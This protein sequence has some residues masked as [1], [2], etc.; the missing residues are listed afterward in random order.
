MPGHAQAPDPA[1]F[2]LDDLAFQACAHE[3]VAFSRYPSEHVL[4]EPAH[5]LEVGIFREGDAEE[6]LD[7]FQRKAAV[8]Q[9][10]VGT[11]RLEQRFFCVVLILNLADDLLEDVLDRHQAG[12]A[13]VLVGD[14]RDVHPRAPEL[15]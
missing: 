5:R 2:D 8:R 10:L 13:A 3:L 12:R 14:D 15:S 7:V 11:Q 6:I 9:D 4:D 1:P